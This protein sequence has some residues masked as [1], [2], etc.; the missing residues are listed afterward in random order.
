MSKFAQFFAIYKEAQQAGLKSTYKEV[1]LDFTEGRTD[2]LSSLP[3]W[4]LDALKL[5]LKKLAV[6]NLKHKPRE[7][8]S[9]VDRTRDKM[10][11]AIIS[12]F[13]SI[14]ATTKQAI[15]WA[16]KYGVFGNKRKFN[17]Y[18]EQ[19]LWQ[20]IRNAEQVKEDHIKAVVKK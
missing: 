1:V 4:E 12:Q 17:E 6:S 11:K 16:E 7:Y 2:S 9:M 19:E 14:G 20:L 13:K 3:E 15:A 10:R 5:N 18:D 8:Y